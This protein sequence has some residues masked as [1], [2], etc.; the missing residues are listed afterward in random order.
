MSV[1]LSS[2]QGKFKCLLLNV[3]FFPDGITPN[4]SLTGPNNTYIYIYIYLY[5]FKTVFK[6]YKVRNDNFFKNTKLSNLTKPS[7]VYIYIYM[8]VCVCEIFILIDIK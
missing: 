2:L 6:F 4:S 3:F 1:T 5:I 7:N 8:C